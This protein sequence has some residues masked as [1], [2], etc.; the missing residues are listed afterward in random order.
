MPL[1]LWVC[2][3]PMAAGSRSPEATYG[4]TDEWEEQG[5]DAGDAQDRA[6]PLLRGGLLGALLR[7]LWQRD[8][9]ELIYETNP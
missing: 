2:L 6:K 5:E 7:S 9:G 4:P 1:L 8:A 3:W